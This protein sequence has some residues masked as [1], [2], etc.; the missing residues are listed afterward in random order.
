LPNASKINEKV[1]RLLCA[2]SVAVNVRYRGLNVG[3][4]Q[5]LRRLFMSGTNLLDSWY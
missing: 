5:G 3:A 4:S 2:T 1:A